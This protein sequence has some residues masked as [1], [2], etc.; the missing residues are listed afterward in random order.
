MDLSLDGFYRALDEKKLTSRKGVDYWMGRDLQKLLGYDTWQNFEQ[1]IERAM[2]AC[3]STGDNPQRWFSVTTKP[4]VSGKGGMQNR[5]D[6]YLSRLACYL[7]AMNG[8]TTKPEIGMAQ[9][10][11]AIQ[12]R[13]QEKFDELT[14]DEKRLELRAR[15]KDHNKYLS[16]AAKRAGVRNFPQFHD[17]GYRGLYGGIGVQAIKRKKGIPENED[18]LDRAGRAEL[19]ANDFRITQTEE[20]LAWVTND[21]NAATRIH[22]GVGQEVRNTIIKI[23]GMLPEHMSP[24]PHIKTLLK[25]Q[26]ARKQLLEKED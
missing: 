17:A 25:K 7:I 20:K 1:V 11:F 4:I 5:R 14:N 19:A 6:Y 22:H 10:Y 2:K 21:E 16:S 9:T 3:E 23:K 8:D 26:K 24:E 12:T 15:V 18:L 13:R